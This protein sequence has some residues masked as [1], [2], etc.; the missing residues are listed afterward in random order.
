MAKCVHLED[1][2]SSGELEGRYRKAKDP[3]L[4]IHLLIVWQLSQDK[5][6]REVLKTQRDRRSPPA[7]G[8]IQVSEGIYLQFLP[9]HSPELQPAE[10]L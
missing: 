2:L 8:R 4:R 1:H 6:I 3:V 9:S 7:L 5:L 10:R